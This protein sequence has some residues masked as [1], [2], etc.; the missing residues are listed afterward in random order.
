MATQLVPVDT[1]TGEIMEAA[2]PVSFGAFLAEIA[3]PRALQQQQQMSAAYDAACRALV[4]PNDVQ[5]ADGREFKKKSAWRK[6][7]R[8]FRVSTEIVR[9]SAE[10]DSE[11]HLVASVIVRATAPWGQ[12]A[13]ALGKCSTRETRFAKPAARAKADHDCPATAQTRATNRAISDLIAAGEVSA[14]EIEGGDQQAYSAPRR[15]RSAAPAEDARPC[16]K[17]A[18]PTWD[19]RQGKK[20]P[21]APDFKCRDKSCDGVIWPPK[22]G[23]E[24]APATAE[25]HAGP[26]PEEGWYGNDDDG[27]PF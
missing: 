2:G 21:R 24:P 22:K 25:I 17:C 18:G 10:W 13:E 26:P 16:P 3:A 23:E 9:E 11:G 4:G 7:G 6:L 27:L 1:T 19:N 20:N 12:Y 15:E 5:M 8:Y 14:E